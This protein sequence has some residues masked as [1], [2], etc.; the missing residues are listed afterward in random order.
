MHVQRG[1]ANSDDNIED[2]N[3]KY[4][5]CH[6]TRPL[7]YTPT[8]RS[9]FILAVPCTAAPKS[10][11]SHPC[12][13]SHARALACACTIA[14]YTRMCTYTHSTAVPQ[15]LSSS[16]KQRLC[17][18]TLTLDTHL[19][20]PAHA[21]MHAHAHPRTPSNHHHHHHHQIQR[22]QTRTHCSRSPA[23]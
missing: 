7:K 23:C 21:R 16:C 1:F 8:S 6:S 11:P 10:Q 4:I 18:H 17:T 5:P 9:K 22:S 19:T 2:F 15:P 13:C 14:A 3:L 12:S 20:H